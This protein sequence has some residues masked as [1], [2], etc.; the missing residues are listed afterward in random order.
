MAHKLDAV[1]IGDKNAP[2]ALATDENKAVNEVVGTTGF[3]IEKEIF[4]GTYPS[5]GKTVTGSVFFK[6][7]YRDKPAVLKIQGLKIEASDAEMA[8]AFENQNRSKIIRAP[9]IFYVQNW[10]AKKGFGLQITEYV[11]AP[12]IYDLPFAT[13]DQ[14]KDFAT[15]YQEYKTKCITRPWVKRDVGKL[16]AS[17]ASR[18]TDSLS[19]EILSID[20]WISNTEAKGRLKLED[21]APFVIRFYPFAAKFIPN[22]KLEFMHG[23]LIAQH[24]YKL[25][26][27][28]YRLFSNI[29]WRYVLE[30]SDLSKNIW[31]NLL[32][33]RS[34]DVSL[35]EVV[36]YVDRW[37]STYKTI[38]VVKK[39]PNF[40]SKMNFLLL[41]R[42]TG[43]LA[44][45]MG[46]S[47]YWGSKEGQKYFRH[48]LGIYQGLFD[49]FADELRKEGRR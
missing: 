27:G 24:I 13:K 23:E 28:T 18:S 8:K 2:N 35:G 9:E 37:L 49:H 47:D 44:G 33:I 1:S 41:E 10:S 29:L 40:E 43:I 4:R 26:D 20:K 11:D 45:D 19:A 46:T 25:G 15:F 16:H 34:N 38:P 22:M 42:M 6:G 12:L 7:L 14:M 48:M 31:W 3:K 30:W 17:G 5:H 36:S 32:Q 39:D 21:Y